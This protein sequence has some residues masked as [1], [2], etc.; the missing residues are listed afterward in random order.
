MRV[1]LLTYGL[2]SRPFTLGYAA[3]AKGLL[4][5][6]IEEIEFAYLDK[7]TNP[8]M[9]RLFPPEVRFVPLGLRRSRWAPFIVAN[10]LK[11]HRPDL[12]ISMPI[13]INIPAIVGWSMLSGSRPKLIVSE[14]ATM[15][16]S[17]FVKNRRSLAWRLLP[18]LARTFYPR[19]S[20]VVCNSSDVAQDL[21]GNIGVKLA[22]DRLKVIVPAVDV[23]AVRQEKS[24]PADHP[25][26]HDGG[27]PIII[28]VARLS[29]E[30]NLALLVNS[31]AQLRQQSD[32]R[33]LILGEGKVRAELEE[34]VGTLGLEQVV[35]MPGHVDNPWKYMAHASLFVLTSTAEAFGRVLVEAMACGVPV[36]ATDA[37]GGGPRTVLDGGRYGILIP[38]G[39]Q[40]A[41]VEAMARLMNDGVY[42]QELCNLGYECVRISDP[43]AVAKAWLD[44]ATLL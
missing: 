35:S 41:L 1:S 4:A 18:T 32:C 12:C 22:P 30:K 27:P 15:S 8:D 17:V 28:T 11:E 5:N 3:L 20:G 23:H 36:I 43:T 39:N 44:F 29:S 24:L 14:R 6:G 21:V 38:T 34:L 13:Q 33:L 31:F 16:Y 2:S 25:W 19:A 10:Y 7:S 37:I 42:R 40:E 9:Q 26:F